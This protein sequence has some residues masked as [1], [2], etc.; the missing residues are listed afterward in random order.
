[1]QPAINLCLLFSGPSKI[2][3]NG[4]GLVEQLVCKAPVFNEDIFPDINCA[5]HLETSRQIVASVLWT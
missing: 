4:V 2:S 5:V 3:T 1:M